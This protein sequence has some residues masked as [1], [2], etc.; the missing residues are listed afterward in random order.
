MLGLLALLPPAFH[1]P[2]LRGDGAAAALVMPQSF[3]YRDAPQGGAGT[4]APAPPGPAVMPGSTIPVIAALSFL[5]PVSLCA[6]ASVCRSLN[7]FAG[8]DPLWRPLARSQWPELEHRAED[9]EWKD[10]YKRKREPRAVWI[11]LYCSC[12]I[13]ACVWR[14]PPGS[15]TKTVFTDLTAGVCP[16]CVWVFLLCCD[17]CLCSVSGY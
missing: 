3:L 10:C 4:D 2:L 13:S 8:F 14:L 7:V 5:D 11:P 6:A 12:C 15:E 16:V 1:G 9:K 17:C